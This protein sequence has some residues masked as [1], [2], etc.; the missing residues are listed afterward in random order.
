MPVNG[1]D[2]HK[3]CEQFIHFYNE[4]REHSELG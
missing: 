4:K 3:V 1:T 2:L